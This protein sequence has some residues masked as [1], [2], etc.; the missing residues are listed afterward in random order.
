M[1]NKEY[2]D[3]NDLIDDLVD[4]IVDQDNNIDQVSINDFSGLT[5]S[6][7]A[8]RTSNMWEILLNYMNT[9]H[10]D[11]TGHT[12]IRE[13]DFPESF[14]SVV[15]F[16]NNNVDLSDNLLKNYI[17]ESIKEKGDTHWNESI[18][19]LIE[20]FYDNFQNND[21]KQIDSTNITV[22]DIKNA[23]AGKS[24]IRP[25]WVIPWENIDK[26]NYEDIRGNDKIKRILKNNINLQF[27]KEQRQNKET[28]V[29]DYIR[30]LMPEYK[31]IIEIE[32]INRNFWVIGQVLTGIC[33]FLFDED[34][35]LIDIFDGLLDEISQLWENIFYLWLSSI[36][37]DSK[38]YE[39][40]QIIYLP[41]TPYK[42]CP[43]TKYDN[44]CQGSYLL[45]NYENFYN[46]AI[47]YNNAAKAQLKSIYENWL[48]YIK[49]KY[50]GTA[51]AIIPEIRQRNYAENFYSRGVYLGIIIYDESIQD[52]DKKVQFLNFNCPIIVDLSTSKFFS[53]NGWTTFTPWFVYET[54]TDYYISKQVNDSAIV[55][56]T[57]F[58]SLL[59]SDFQGNFTKENDDWMITSM[60]MIFKD[61]VKELNGITSTI[62]DYTLNQ[63]QDI[64]N[65]SNAS[66]ISQNSGTSEWIPKTQ[67][68]YRGELLS[69]YKIKTQN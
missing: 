65:I 41:I 25:Q 54:D 61:T 60:H 68:Y 33:S 56:T 27:T 28:S 6:N 37:E 7:F 46:N 14:E 43:Y 63:N 53:T 19:K 29:Y 49:D 47:D 17:K 59:N 9:K 22:G 32:D 36:I 30:L 31:R 39:N 42:N 4:G 35:P 12:F 16:I 66:T 67:G 1:I 5:L 34:S 64:I 20:Y 2:Q 62:I 58:H 48:G 8:R 40:M 3:S 18:D 55:A 10:M 21:N 38:R 51:I 52:E 23:D 15:K 24:F 13:S 69:W 57:V 26:K 11:E 44:F 50:N 45:D